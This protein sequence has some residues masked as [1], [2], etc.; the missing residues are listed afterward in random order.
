LT[1]LAAT[2]GNYFSEVIINELTAVGGLLLIG[3]GISILEIK[4]LK[5]LNM[6]PALVVIILIVYF[7]A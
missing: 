6:T 2:F 5:I 7:F 4:P 1:L 3:L